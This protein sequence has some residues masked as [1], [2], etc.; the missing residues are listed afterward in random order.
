MQTVSKLY[1]GHTS[2][3]EQGDVVLTLDGKLVTRA[4]DI[5]RP[6]LPATLQAVI[7]RN[8]EQISLEISTFWNDEVETSRMVMFCG[9]TLHRPPLAA[10]QALSNIHSEVYVG[11]EMCGTNASRYGLSER[12]FITHVDGV[13]TPD[14][15]SFLEQVKNIPDNK[16]FR[17][18]GVDHWEVRFVKTIRKDTHYW[19]TVE[20]RR[21]KEADLGWSIVQI[22]EVVTTE[23]GDTETAEVLETKVMENGTT[24]QEARVE[25]ATEALEKT[26]IILREEG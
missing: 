8:L 5:F 1:A 11:G 21:D 20:Y 22:D 17:L 6:D 25:H 18:S 7:V 10:R 24:E 16:Y 4:S 9:A 3:L 23:K 14:L 26:Y 19:P 13:A 2:G 15:D 12:S